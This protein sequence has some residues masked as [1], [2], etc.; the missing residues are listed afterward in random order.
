MNIQDKDGWTPLHLA[1]QEGYSEAAG[2][3]I[4][5]GASVSIRNKNGIALLQIAVDSGNRPVEEMLR[6]HGPGN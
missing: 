1:A 3:L 2:L 4:A 6:R 5:A